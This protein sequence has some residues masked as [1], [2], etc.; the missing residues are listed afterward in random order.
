LKDH[1]FLVAFT[2][3]LKKI[4]TQYTRKNELKYSTD[5]DVTVAHEKFE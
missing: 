5:I 1:T 4:S 3:Y 2:K